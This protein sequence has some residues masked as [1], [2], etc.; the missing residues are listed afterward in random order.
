MRNNARLFAASP[1]LLKACQDLIA[2]GKAGEDT[3]WHSECKAVQDVFYAMMVAI[4][5]ATQV[6]PTPP[7]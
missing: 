2:L 4:G 1:K 3:S 6:I 7:A 5:E